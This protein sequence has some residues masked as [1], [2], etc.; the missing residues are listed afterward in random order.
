MACAGCK[1]RRE[2]IKAKAGESIR[3]VARRLPGR[4]SPVSRVSTVT[5]PKK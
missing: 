3:A 5:L 1:R 4:K 2:I